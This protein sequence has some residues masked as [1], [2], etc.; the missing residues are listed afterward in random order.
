MIT[1]SASA[2]L[3]AHNL[4]KEATVKSR[5]LICITPITLFAALAVPPQLAAQHTRYRLVVI[6]TL[7][8]PQ[9]YGDGGHGAANINSRGVAAGV[10][11]TAVLD[12]FYP[13]FN[14]VLTGVGSYPYVFHAFTT[15]GGKLLIWAAYRVPIAVRP[16]ISRTTALLPERRRTDQLTRSQ[17]GRS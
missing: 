4:N 15:N 1:E 9:S 2:Y 10:A 17:D 14:P 8:G 12:P 5:I 3:A 16:P 6:G 7:G 13:N 11:D